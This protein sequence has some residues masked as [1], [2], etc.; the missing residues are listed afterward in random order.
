MPPGRNRG[1]CDGTRKACAY[2][3]FRQSVH[4]KRRCCFVQKKSGFL[5]EERNSKYGVYVNDSKRNGKIV[6]KN[7]D[8]FALANYSFYVDGSFLYTSG[9]SNI[10]IKGLEVCNVAKSKSVQ[11]YP[12]FNRSTR[13]KKVLPQEN[14]EVLDPPPAPKKPRGNIILQ[15]LPAIIMLGAA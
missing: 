11:K 5:L 15:L 6:L 8:F 1:K 3:E 14:I 13:L 9:D 12:H 4:R 7:G 2:C 10:V